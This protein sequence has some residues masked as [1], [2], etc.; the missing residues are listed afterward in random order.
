MP[1][2]HEYATPESDGELDAFRCWDG[3]P[4]IPW[5]EETENYV[6]AWMLG[7]AEH[8][9]LFRDPEGEL[10]A[11][12][13]FDRRTVEVP[14]VAPQA[15]PSWHLQVIAIDLDHQ[16]QHLFDEVLPGVYEEMR[17]LDPERVLF[18]GHVHHQNTASLRAAARHDIDHFFW[19]DDHYVV[20]LGEVPEQ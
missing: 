11:V 4:D 9:L 14:L 13:A 8:V 6:R 1:L 20:V 19:R 15:H 17:R 16:N 5:V 18:T 2:T 3:T 7:T 12:A 10:V